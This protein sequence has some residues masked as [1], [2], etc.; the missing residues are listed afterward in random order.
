MQSGYWIHLKS[1]MSLVRMCARLPD[2]TI[3]NVYVLN[4]YNLLKSGGLAGI[5]CGGGVWEVSGEPDD[6]DVRQVAAIL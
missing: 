5:L 3:V 4:P 6:N 1:G 2:F